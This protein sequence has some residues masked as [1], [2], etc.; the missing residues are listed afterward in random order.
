MRKSYDAIIIETSETL[1]RYSGYWIE[2]LLA[3]MSSLRV[4]ILSKSTASS[5][6]NI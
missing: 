2:M 6:S 4:C 3:A 1:Q 5:L